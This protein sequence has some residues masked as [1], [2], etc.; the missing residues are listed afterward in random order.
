MP[1]SPADELIRVGNALIV[2]NERLAKRVADQDAE[3]ARLRQALGNAEGDASFD[4]H[5]K[6]VLATTGEQPFLWATEGEADEA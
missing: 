1:K 2:E 4:V 5:R 6:T 3:I